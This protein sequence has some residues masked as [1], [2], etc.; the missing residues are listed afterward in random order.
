MSAPKVLLHLGLP[1]TA[2]S[3]LQ[4]NVFQTLHKRGKINFLG[5]CLDYNYKTSQLSVVNYSGKFIRDAAEE[6]ITVLAAQ[7]ELAMILDVDR[8]NVFSDEGLMIA[9]PGNDNISLV[10]KFKNL[11]TVFRDYNTQVFVTLRDPIDYLYALY[12]ELYPDYLSRVR[13]LNSVQRY[14]ERLL[15]DPK[16]LLFESFFYP[17]WLHELEASFDVTV[18]QYE[19]LGTKCS[20]SC[21]KWADILGISADEFWNIFQVKRLNEKEKTGQ[22]VRKVHDLKEIENKFR[23][24]FSYNRFLFDSTRWV[25]RHCGMQRLLRYRFSSLA[26]HRYPEGDQYLRLKNIFE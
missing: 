13:D 9:Y 25:Y 5:K 10:R 6:K 23:A 19:D 11:N 4:H 2:T 12:V 7:K 24:C 18:L 3:S 16:D 8:L 26:T 17:L 1:K 21:Q 22:E 20:F 15:S 14:V